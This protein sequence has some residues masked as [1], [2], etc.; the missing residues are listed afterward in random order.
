MA[1]NTLYIGD[2]RVIAGGLVRP[3]DDSCE[4][5]IQH[6][7]IST[8]YRRLVVKDGRLAGVIL[9]GQ[10]EDA[11]VYLNL[12]YNRTPLASLPVDPRQPGFHVGRLLG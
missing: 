2:T 4:V 10:V 7:P 8:S 12:I 11:G 9:V 3:D 5:H 1:Q 6:D